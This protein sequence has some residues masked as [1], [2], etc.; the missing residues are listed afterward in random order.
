[1]GASRSTTAGA[2]PSRRY[3][4]SLRE[5]GLGGDRSSLAEAG[6][7]GDALAMLAGGAEKLRGDARSLQEEMDVVLPREA[8]AAE[9]LDR[10]VGDVGRRVRGASL[11]H[12]G[13]QRKRLGLRVG[14]PGRVVGERAC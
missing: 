1:M 9:G 8:D 7:L 5:A 12:R 14:G 10:V 11:G 4:G 3:A 13:G 2:R 6:E